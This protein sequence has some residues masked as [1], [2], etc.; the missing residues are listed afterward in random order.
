M[1][2]IYGTFGPA[3]CEQGILEEM[4]RAGMT[5]M[6]LNLSH[7]SLEESAA[8]VAAFHAAADAAGVQPEL[9]IDMQGP[10]LRIGVLPTALNLSQGDTVVL[11]RGGI[12]VPDAVMPE[13]N[14]GDEV[15]LDDG[16]ISVRITENCGSYAAAE[17][18]RGGV[19]TSRKSIKLK[20]PDAVV[21]LPVLT[22]HD[23]SNVRLAAQYGVTGLMQP[24]VRSGE[25]LHRV[26]ESLRENGGEHV[27]I[28]AKI[29]NMQGVSNLEDI[30]PFADVVIIARGDLGNDMELWELPGVQKDISALCRAHNK[31]FVVVTQMLASMERS[32]VPT[33]AEVSDI[34]NAVTD[35]A[36]GVMVTGETAV[37]SYPVEAIRYL[38]NTARSASERLEK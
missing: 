32:P 17:V 33:R 1:V 2:S 6:R 4:F 25:E 15:V 12:P 7:T 8:W 38:A 3:C 36:C 24:F 16:K 30:L 13:L 29:E 14:A 5:G 19:L 34:F 37:G 18:M 23:I 27:K 10:E 28:Y 9:L 22:D 35:G 20:N 11:G 21:E 26:R 31:P